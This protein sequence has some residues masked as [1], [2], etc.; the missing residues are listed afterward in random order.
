[1]KV[2]SVTPNSLS[3]AT[4]SLTI[5]NFYRAAATDV[6]TSKSTSSTF[7]TINRE[8]RSR[9]QSAL[10]ICFQYFVV[11][12]SCVLIVWTSTICTEVVILY[13]RISGPIP[14]R[15]F[16]SLLGKITRSSLQI[17]ASSR[18]LLYL[19]LE[20]PLCSSCEISYLEFLWR[21]TKFAQ[22]KLIIRLACDYAPYWK[23][24]PSCI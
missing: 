12:I 6:L 14:P 20:S 8:R 22:T 9:E 11:S 4:S 3:L 1:M 7:S 13:T 5:L 15:A 21:A 23:S 2:R 10:N 19:Y 16:I 18:M 17:G 24:S